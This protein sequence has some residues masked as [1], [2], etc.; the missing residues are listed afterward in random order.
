MSRAFVN[1]D[2][3]Q[4]ADQP[5]ERLLSDLPNHVT[6][7]GL[8]RLQQQVADI[9]AEVTQLRQSGNK[10]DQRLAD[11]QRDLRYFQ[12]RLGSAQVVVLPEQIDRVMIGTQ[13]TYLDEA[14]QSHQVQL[15]GEDE[16]SP[17]QGLINWA[18]PLGRALLGRQVGDVVVWQRPAG[19]MSIEITA[20][21]R[22][23]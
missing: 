14:D 15:V 2:A 17:E 3:I 10:G 8:Q 5:A 12:A 22:P 7:R 16:A 20:V 18:S 4:Q 9:T 19:A 11:L 23:D 13:V 1:E 21:I 6:P